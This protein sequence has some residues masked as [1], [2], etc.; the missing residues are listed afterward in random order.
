MHESIKGKVIVIS[1]GGRGLGRAMALGLVKAGARV[2]LTA[3][4]EGDELIQTAQDCQSIGGED[5]VASIK[6]DVSD[7]YDC[8]RVMD[9]GLR[10]WGHL[11]MLI[12]NAGRGM[13]YVDSNFVKARPPFWT[14]GNEIWEM[15]VDTNLNGVF[16][17]SK[18]ATP[19]FLKEGWG[20]IVNISTSLVTMQRKGYSPYGSTKWAVEGLTMIMAQDFEDTDITA[21]ILIPGGATDT[22]MIPGNVGDKS[23]AGADGNLFEPDIM[24]P[25]AQYLAS[26]LSDKKNGFRYVAK[27]WNSSLQPEEAAENSRFPIRRDRQ[28]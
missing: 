27:L 22:A 10:K 26:S 17:M 19:Y 7:V 9:V 6:A 28:Y 1:G 23:R 25:P 21:N 3:A 8:Q 13:S 16:N 20:R 12:N 2:L 5:C 15:I 11:H 24:V 14:I 4:R 18:A